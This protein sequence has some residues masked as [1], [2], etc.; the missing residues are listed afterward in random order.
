MKIRRIGMA[1]AICFLMLGMPSEAEAA[2]RPIH[3]GFSHT[4]GTVSGGGG[5]IFVFFGL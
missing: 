2:A 1:L 5:N 3:T 4:G